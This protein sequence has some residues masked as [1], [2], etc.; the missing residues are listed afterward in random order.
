MRN[1]I[2]LL[3]PLPHFGGVVRGRGSIPVILV[4]GSEV[5]VWC[6]VIWYIFCRAFIK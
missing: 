2:H 6:G 1:C 3:G 4:G 5:E